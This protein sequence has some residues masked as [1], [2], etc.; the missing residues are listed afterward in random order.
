LS[1]TG[2][3][4]VIV[5]D[6]KTKEVRMKP[7]QFIPIK[8]KQPTSSDKSRIQS[9]S[10]GKNSYTIIFP[11]S[12]RPPQGW[13]RMFREVLDSIEDHPIRTPKPQAFVHEQEMRI[14]CSLEDIP[15]YFLKLKAAV[16]TTNQKYLQ[17]LQQKVDEE[18]VR[19]QNQDRLKS[20]EEQA[21]DKVLD[22]LD[23]S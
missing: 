13:D 17:S 9:D 14:I 10:T 21:I 19:R 20:P 22:T 5:Y 8:I 11:F 1:N 23:Y 16:E 12:S 7:T 18:E 3:D 6:K 15:T 4:K 2:I